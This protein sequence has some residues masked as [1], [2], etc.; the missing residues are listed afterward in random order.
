MKNNKFEFTFTH[1]LAIL[2][3]LVFIIILFSSRILNKINDINN[4]LFMDR[5]KEIFDIVNNRDNTN[6]TMYSST[7][8]V[9]SD[10]YNDLDYCIILNADGDIDKIAIGGKKYYI[11]KDGVT[12]INSIINENIINE[13]YPFT[14]CNNIIFNDENNCIF[15]NGRKP[16]IG[17]VYRN[18]MFEYRYNY[19]LDIDNTKSD[20]PSV[21]WVLN[22]KYEGWGVSLI[23][24]NNEYKNNVTLCTSINN[25]PVVSMKH[26]FTG[27]MYESDFTNFSTKNIVDMSYMFYYYHGN[28]ILNLNTFNTDNVIDMSYMFDR[29]AIKELDISSFNIVKVTNINGMFTNNRLLTKVLVKDKDTKIKIEEKNSM[30]DRLQIYNK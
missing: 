11:I 14:S 19:H 6:V 2:I 28:Q 24:R 25:E 3:I 15:D 22:D 29:A 26:L 27:Y 18:G 16:N 4:K 7:D 13:E 10:E 20:I 23:D 8:N 9:I 12:D 1:F 5:V 21:K 30:N 17:E